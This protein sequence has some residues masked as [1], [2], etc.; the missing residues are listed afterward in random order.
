MQA[1]L[2]GYIIP[3]VP[4]VQRVLAEFERTGAT[5]NFARVGFLYQVRRPANIAL[6][7]RACIDTTT[8]MIH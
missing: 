5:S 3:V 7:P 2:V 8:P 1:E 6:T 4:V